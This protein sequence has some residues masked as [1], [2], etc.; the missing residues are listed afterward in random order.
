ML[1]IVVYSLTRVLSV[2][3]ATGIDSVPCLGWR[4]LLFVC[5]SYMEIPYGSILNKGL[6]VSQI[7]SHVK[8]KRQVI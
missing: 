2:C 5:S 3:C 1:A 6:T 7:Q 4:L 8:E